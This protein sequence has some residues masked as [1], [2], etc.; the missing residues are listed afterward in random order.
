MNVFWIGLALSYVLPTIPLVLSVFLLRRALRPNKR[1]H[2]LSFGASAMVFALS[3]LWLCKSLTQLGR[4]GDRAANAQVLQ[5][6]SDIHLSQGPYYCVSL[7]LLAGAF[8]GALAW[9]QK[10]EGG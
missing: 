6:W 5:A 1:T 7:A 3:S 9:R 10:G 8:L 4:L 2:W